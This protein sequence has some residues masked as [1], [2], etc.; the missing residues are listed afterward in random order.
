MKGLTPEDCPFCKRE[1]SHIIYED[2]LAYAIPDKHPIRRG[3]I[4]L[5]PKQHIG[6]FY[7]LAEE[8]YNHLFQVAQK[9]SKIL[10]EKYKPIRVGLG[11]FGFDINHVHI[12]LVPMHDRDD[13]VPGYVLTKDRHT[14][15]EEEMESIRNEINHYKS[16]NFLY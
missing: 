1:N 4:L 10:K 8:T 11:I 2:D 15:D 14:S 3:H 7:E 5:I 12:H 9:L 6:D 13:I 16:S